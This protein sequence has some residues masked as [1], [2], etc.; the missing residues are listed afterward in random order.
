MP[1]VN[2]AKKKTKFNIPAARKHIWLK[3][4]LNE[5]M[6]G[7]RDVRKSRVSSAHN[8]KVNQTNQIAHNGEPLAA[9]CPI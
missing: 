3:F 2:S 6:R 7:C 9:L 1:P 4:F 5:P 8:K